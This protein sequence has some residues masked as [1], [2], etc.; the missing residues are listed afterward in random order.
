MLQAVKNQ[1]R[2]SESTLQ[3][4]CIGLYSCTEFRVRLPGLSQYQHPRLLLD[5]LFHALCQCRLHTD[6]I[7]I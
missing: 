2:D 5:L 7:R 3:L 6:N 1:S 4:V